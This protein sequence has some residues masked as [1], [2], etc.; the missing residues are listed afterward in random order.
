MRFN[1]NL[2]KEAYKAGYKKAKFLNEDTRGAEKNK[3]LFKKIWNFLHK[4]YYI[5]IIY[6]IDN[7]RSLGYCDWNMDVNLENLK[8]TTKQGHNIELFE[9][10]VAG[11]WKRNNDLIIKFD[12]NSHVIITFY[13]QTPV[14]ELDVFDDVKNWNWR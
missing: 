9:K 1:R 3:G 14:K 2:Y 13:K 11:V 4:D 12:D 6:L 8:L 5:R 7:V 10:D